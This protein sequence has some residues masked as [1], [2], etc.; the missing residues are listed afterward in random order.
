[1]RNVGWVSVHEVQA[2]RLSH[3]GYHWVTKRTNEE[4]GAG[5]FLDA[6][7]GFA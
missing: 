6:L 4:K 5:E 3:T 2:N 7:L 1:V